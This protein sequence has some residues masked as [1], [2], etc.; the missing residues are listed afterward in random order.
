MDLGDI[1]REGESPAPVRQPVEV[2]VETPEEV[3][4]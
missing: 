2:P 3:E 4:V 1:E